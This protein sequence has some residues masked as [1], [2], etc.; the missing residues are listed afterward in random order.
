MTRRARGDLIKLKGLLWRFG[1]V[2][3][4]LSSNLNITLAAPLAT[5]WL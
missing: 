1:K 3:L 2:A 4:Y 5:P